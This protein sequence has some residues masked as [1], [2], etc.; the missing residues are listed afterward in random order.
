L[1]N[2]ALDI[3]K[4]GRM[5]V[6]EIVVIGGRGGVLTTAEDMALA[7]FNV[8]MWTAFPQEYKP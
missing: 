5:P 6:R 8:R 2:K 4:G 3:E 7:G 1:G